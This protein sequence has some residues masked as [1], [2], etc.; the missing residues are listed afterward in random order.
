MDLGDSSE[1]PNTPLQ[2]ILQRTT[3]LPLEA[4]LKTD[5]PALVVERIV[6]STVLDQ[7]ENYLE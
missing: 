7:S 5:H 6:K 1:K 2:R 4:T 3:E